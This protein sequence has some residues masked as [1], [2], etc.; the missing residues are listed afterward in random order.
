M[1]HIQADAQFKLFVWR[2]P[3]V[4]DVDARGYI[5]AL[6]EYNFTLLSYVYSVNVRGSYRIK[7]A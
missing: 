5:S 7:Y 6:T 3:H 1:T 2:R 4:Y